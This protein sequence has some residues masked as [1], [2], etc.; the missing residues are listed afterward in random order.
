RQGIRLRRIS[1][2]RRKCIKHH[3]E[4]DF[5]VVQEFRSLFHLARNG[6][7]KSDPNGRKDDV[8]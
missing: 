8:R 3:D 1:Q 6:V 5:Q 4:V 2:N 7:V